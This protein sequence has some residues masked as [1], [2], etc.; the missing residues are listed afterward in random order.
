MTLGFKNHQ[1]DILIETPVEKEK[2]FVVISTNIMTEDGKVT[3]VR[4][5]LETINGK[6]L[7][8]LLGQKFLVRKIHRNQ[9]IKPQF[10][11]M[12]KDFFAVKRAKIV[13]FL[14]SHDIEQDEA[15][16]MSILY[17]ESPEYHQQM[18]N[19]KLDQSIMLKHV[20]SQASTHSL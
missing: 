12:D 10:V 14:D 11:P 16:R 5:V 13:D 15:R 19:N 18:L 3:F 4:K 6:K 1:N 8:P 7:N 20:S 9:A 2:T 17:K